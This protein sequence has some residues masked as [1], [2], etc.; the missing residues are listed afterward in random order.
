M[1]LYYAKGACSL[2]VRI[3]IHEMGRP[4]KFESVNLQTKITETGVNFLTI[5]PKGSV[6]TL[7]TDTQEILTE[8]GVIQQYLADTYKAAE[9]LP[10]MGDMKRY[11]V[12]EWLNFVSTDLHKGFGPLFNAKVPAEIKDDIFKPILKAKFSF[13]D[14]HLENKKYLMGEKFT[15]PDGYLF[16]LLSWLPHMKI[17]IAEWSNLARYF[18]DVKNRPA[19]QQALQDEGLV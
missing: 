6:P 15:L 16:V 12:L 13:V 14:K 3:A 17:D 4:C 19:V 2:A 18:T 1:K 10:P 7:E 9:L 11:R 5:N 8:N